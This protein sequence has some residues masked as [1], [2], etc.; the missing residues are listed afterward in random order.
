MKNLVIL[1][2][3]LGGA[4][5]LSACLNLGS[6]KSHD[7]NVVA[8][9]ASP[10]QSYVATSYNSSGGGAAGWCYVQVNV[11]KQTEQF[12]PDSGVV[13]VTKCSVKPD[14]KWENQNKLSI[15]YPADATI[16]TQLKAWRSGEVE[17]SYLP[18]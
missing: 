5:S 4:V 11:R 18:K 7:V 6:D 3:F 9:F 13:F 12:N 16:Y 10:N 1:V 14:V 15:G 17:I 8:N 2:V